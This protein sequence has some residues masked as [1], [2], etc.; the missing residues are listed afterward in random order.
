MKRG[1]KYSYSEMV[2]DIFKRGNALIAYN[3]EEK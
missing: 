1:K 3:T 2:V